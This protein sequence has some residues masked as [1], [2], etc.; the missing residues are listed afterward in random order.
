MALEEVDA[1]EGIGWRPLTTA[2]T[3]TPR[4]AASAGQLGE[5]ADPDAA[6]DDQEVPRAGIEREAAAERADQRRHHAGRQPRQ[7]A[8]AGADHADA[9]VDRPGLDVEVVHRDRPRQDDHR[10]VGRRDRDHDELAGQ[11]GPGDL[12]RS[13]A[14]HPVPVADALD[15]RDRAVHE[16]G[17]G[18]C[19]IGRDGYQPGHRVAAVAVL[20]AVVDGS[21]VEV[22][23]G[24]CRSG[25]ACRRARRTRRRGGP[26]RGP[27][28]W[29]WSTPPARGSARLGS[30]RTAA[31]PAR[32]G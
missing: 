26:R 22:M 27:G 17:H 9:Q 18:R 29:R 28:R 20:V 15:G 7:A 3:A 21:A 14:Q 11:R 32:P 2:V 31:R 4:R 25:S 24:P 19:R 30:A 6:A 10:L 1:D 16:A 23:R 12:G 13:E 8:G 5:R